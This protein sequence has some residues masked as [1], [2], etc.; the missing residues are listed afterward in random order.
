VVRKT[1]RNRHLGAG[2]QVPRV[3]P[4]RGVVTL[5]ELSESIGS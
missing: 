1:E 5:E 3:S 4:Y 2:E